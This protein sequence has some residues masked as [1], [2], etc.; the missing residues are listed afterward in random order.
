MGQTS[1]TSND[2]ETRISARKS[3]WEMTRA[4]AEL[5][6]AAAALT[7]TATYYR[8]QA[9]AAESQVK[10]A[11]LNLEVARAQAENSLLQGASSNDAKRRSMALYLAEVLDKPFAAKLAQVLS[12]A[13]PS[14]QVRSHAASML[15]TL[16]QSREYDVKLIAANGVTNLQI[17]AELRSKGL[18]KK[19]SDADGY[20]AG[21]NDF[22]SEKALQLYREVL[23][24]LSSDT[25]QR[26][27]AELLRGVEEDL[28]SG[29][30]DTA[31]LKLQA[32]FAE[33]ARAAG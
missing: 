11:Q 2:L 6:I 10:I 24:E 14:A 21:R 13:D 27:D 30:R 9:G 8:K 7:F 25:K 33:V 26:L 15:R 1:N 4:V 32:M 19:I 16:C 12:V 22:G 3:R 28:R 20:L 5:L 31:L 17:L 23:A 29:H 18:L